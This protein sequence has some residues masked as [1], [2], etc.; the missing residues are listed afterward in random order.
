MALGGWQHGGGGVFGPVISRAS[1][2]GRGRLAGP[3]SVPFS[4]S[5][6]PKSAYLVCASQ[7]WRMFS[8]PDLCDPD[9]ELG[10]VKE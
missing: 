4:P 1:Q 6:V 2:E 3:C 9:L 8:L 10:V 5:H 7:K